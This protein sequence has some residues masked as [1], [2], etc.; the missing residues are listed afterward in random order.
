MTPKM[1]IIIPTY[2][3]AVKEERSPV[4]SVIIPTY[5][6]ERTLEKCLDSIKHQDYEGTIEI[7][8]VDNFSKD[9]TKKIADKFGV[10]FIEEK[11]E[12]SKARNTGAK[13]IKGKYILYI[14]SDMY[15]SESVI[16]ECIK[17]VEQD[18]NKV[19][20][21]IPEK[22]IGTG[23][24]IK[25]RNFE[26]VFYNATCIDAIRFV[27]AK[28]FRE[29]NGFDENLIGG[30]DWD[31]DRRIKGHGETGIIKGCLYHDEG[32]FNLSNYLKKKKLYSDTLDKYIEKWGKEDL[33]IKKQVGATYR[34]MGVF[35]EYGK[36]KRIIKKPYLAFATFVLRCLVGLYYIKTE[37][38]QKI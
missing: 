7:I 21:Y 2:N 31:V 19:A 16:S 30:E 13:N 6:S 12:R 38:E 18:I 34:L 17:I 26:R 33:I 3:P 37:L 1:S 8:V 23:F 35:I 36:W 5:N 4:V 10:K 15:L 9:N 11:S 14:D 29:I 32:V 25:V 27:R 24:L 20:L 22:I 28:T